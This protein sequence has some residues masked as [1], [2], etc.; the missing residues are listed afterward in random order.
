MTLQ[1][2]AHDLRTPISAAIHCMHEL[3]QRAAKFKSDVEIKD[4]NGVPMTA[5]SAGE[6]LEGGGDDGHRVGSESGRACAAE[7]EGFAVALAALGDCID[8][9]EHT[10]GNI[11]AAVGMDNALT[12]SVRTSRASEMDVRQL[13]R[14]AVLISSKGSAGICGAG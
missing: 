8:V 10:I 2:A 4:A 11:V 6:Y 12:E 9:A 5:G 1:A 14:R 3:R 13:L 7:T